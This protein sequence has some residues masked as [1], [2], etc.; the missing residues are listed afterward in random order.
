MYGGKK[1][2]RRGYTFIEL[3]GVIVLLGIILVIAIPS[4]T[5]A[6]KTSRIKSEEV[7]LDKLS[8]TI[9]SYVTLNSDSL[10]F[11]S[12]GSGK[13]RDRENEENVPI[14]KATTTMND[15]INSNLIT[16]KDFKDPAFDTNC[17]KDAV[18]EIYRDSDY[19]YCHKVRIDNL[20][21]LSSDYIEKLREKQEED[22]WDYAINTCIWSRE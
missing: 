12:A 11:E 13:K 10:S 3:L 17:N 1:M 19:V 21:C 6:L 15:I 5:D 7:F 22:S 14:Y 9:D 18:V 8:D 20:N 4:I 16:E 2:N